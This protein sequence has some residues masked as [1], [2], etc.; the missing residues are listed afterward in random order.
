MSNSPPTINSPHYCN[1]LPYMNLAVLYYS[2][3]G[4]GAV[5]IDVLNAVLVYASMLTT[6]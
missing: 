4:I 1:G 2:R 3:V 6:S 5:N